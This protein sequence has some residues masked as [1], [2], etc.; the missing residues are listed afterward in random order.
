MKYEELAAQQYLE[1]VAIQT[2]SNIK[3]RISNQKYELSLLASEMTAKIDNFSDAEFRNFLLKKVN[4]EQYFRLG[5]AFP[6]G[7]ALRFQENIGEI[8]HVDYSNI[9]CFHEA[10]AGK[11]CLEKLLKCLKQNQVM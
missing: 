10:L 1:A 8:E 4:L 9:N 6:D 11:P 3:S 2:A 5:F 7:R